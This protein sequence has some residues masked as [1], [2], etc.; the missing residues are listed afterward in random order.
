MG[1]ELAVALTEAPGIS[2]IV[3]T[4]LGEPLV[5]DVA[6][7]RWSRIQICVSSFINAEARHSLLDLRH[8][9]ASIFSKVS[10]LVPRR[11]MWTST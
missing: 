10:C 3:L 9:L 2:Y 6:S 7:A 11:L 5:P 8:S 4:D 1:R